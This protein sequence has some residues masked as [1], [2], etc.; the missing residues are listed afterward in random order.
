M[1]RYA[2]EIEALQDGVLTGYI[3]DLDAP[4]QPIELLV[5]VDFETPFAIAADGYRADL[6]ERF[7]TPD[8]INAGFRIDLS[9][10]IG[11]STDNLSVRIGLP[12]GSFELPGS[13]LSLSVE[14]EAFVDQTRGGVVI[15]WAHGAWFKH[16]HVELWADDTFLL[17]WPA[18]QERDDLVRIGVQNGKC[19]FNIPVRLLF[20]DEQPAN[21]NIRLPGTEIRLAVPADST[22]FDPPGRDIAEAKSN[23]IGTL[24]E[25][26]RLLEA[27]TI[28]CARLSVAGPEDIQIGFGTLQSLLDR[29]ESL[30]ETRAMLLEQQSLIRPAAGA[31]A[32]AEAAMGHVSLADHVR[33]EAQRSGRSEAD[34][35]AQ[36][37]VQIYAQDQS[38][39]APLLQSIDRVADAGMLAAIADGFRAAEFLAVAHQVM[40]LSLKHNSVPGRA[41]VRSLRH[42]AAWRQLAERPKTAI[43]SRRRLVDQAG[44]ARALYCIWRSLPHETTGYDTRSHYL[45]RGF[46]KAGSDVIACTRPGFPWDSKPVAFGQSFERIDGIHYVRL[47]S[48]GINDRVLPL[49]AYL[50]AHAN[51]IAHLAIVGGV[52]LIHS[53]TNW[54]VGLPALMAARHLGLPFVYEMRGLVEVTRSSTVPGYAETDHFDLFRRMEA[55]VAGAADLTF[56]ITSGVRHEMA[57]R[58]CDT[59]RFRLAPNGVDIERFKP[60]PRDNAL[61]YRLGLGTETVFGFIGSFVNYEG[62]AELCEAAAALK[63]RGRRFKLLLVGDGPYAQDVRDAIERNGIADVTIMTGRMPFESVPR[64]YSLVDVAVYPRLGMEVT[65]IVSPLKPFEAMAMGKPVIGSNVAAIADIIQHGETGW[66]FEKN[67]TGALIAALELV[68]ADPLVPQR[69]GAAARAFVT[70]NH[71]WTDIAGRISE[72]WTDLRRQTVPGYA[73]G[74]IGRTYAGVDDAVV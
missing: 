19:A 23:A 45:L 63:A 13:P 42:K 71:D 11:R 52:D 72:G 58:G 74:N 24:D 41:A 30:T 6:S 14:A 29:I 66:L 28:A 1:P 61:A 17:N 62:L 4:Y 3:V 60:L 54:L 15:G 34:V 8:G 68:L 70:A 65:E 21:L 31:T 47:G 53:A 44:S 38:F 67:D 18:D 69:L 57:R 26:H 16:C 2:A 55:D 25:L 40:A 33:S 39:R 43:T 32:A 56:T 46:Q 50:Q 37:L 59:S 27:E 10:A 48:K 49:D 22:T 7:R 73:A 36:D 9:D 64:F 51:R 20:G 12:D 5:T 35:I